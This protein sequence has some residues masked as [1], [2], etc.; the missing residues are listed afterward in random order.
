MGGA[1]PCHEGMVCLHLWNEATEH[2]IHYHKWR[3]VSI[4]IISFCTIKFVDTPSIDDTI[5]YRVTGFLKTFLAHTVTIAISLFAI[6]WCCSFWLVTLP[7]S[8]VKSY[9]HNDVI[10][11][12]FL[13]WNLSPILIPPEY[14]K[15]I[16]IYN[17]Y[18]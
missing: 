4:I 2:A 3:W 9:E 12:C 10:I 8:F 1:D 7:K 15:N 18:I 16:S 6:V 17:Y 13:L 14:K 5:Y 11:H